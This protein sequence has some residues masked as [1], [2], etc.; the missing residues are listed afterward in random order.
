MENG[1]MPTWGDIIKKAPVA[2]LF[3]EIAEHNTKLIFGVMQR[4][5]KIW[6]YGT[7]RDLWLKEHPNAT[8]EEVVEMK[9]S[10]ARFTNAKFGGMNWE[11]MG[12]TK[13]ELTVAR[14]FIFAPDWFMSNIESAR[15]AL[16]GGI[17]KTIKGSARQVPVIGKR[18]TPGAW[19]SSAGSQNARRFWIQGMLAA[20][21]ATQMTSI[22]LTGHRSKYWT[23]VDLGNGKYLNIYF[24][25]APGELV[26]VINAIDRNGLIG[27]M[28]RWSL[29]KGNLAA[30]AYLQGSTGETYAG[31]KIND[32]DLDWKAKTIR[33]TAYEAR[34]VSPVP[35]SFQNIIDSW[36][37]GN[38][39][40]DLAKDIATIIVGGRP[41]YPEKE[42]KPTTRPDA[43]L[44]EQIMTGKSTVSNRPPEAVE[45]TKILRDIRE[46]KATA[47]EM[48][49]A[50]QVATRKQ[51]AT[52]QRQGKLTPLQRQVKGASAQ[53]AVIIYDK[54]TP[55]QRREI[56]P[57]VRAKAQRARAEGWDWTD[58]GA[59]LAKKY[60]GVDVQRVGTPG[61]IKVR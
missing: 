39:N 42:K 55:E 18:V 47:E 4:K 23:Q 1:K 6:T 8:P 9:T 32:P 49:R 31:K 61:A 19:E 10:L 30:R 51:I 43:T 20:G 22:L 21:F 24:T 2:K 60:F 54:A 44:M 5:M 56:A 45:H 34:T 53:A 3:N 36:T 58:H 33:T 28:E 48:A 12:W 57:L 7:M 59:E 13:T 25:G 37:M 38:R 46:G 17:G 41:A 26:N 27:G 35:F 11:M 40:K 14:F 15:M 52:A 50:G 16:E 29:G